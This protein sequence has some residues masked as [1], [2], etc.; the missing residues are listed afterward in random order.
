M[1]TT[2]PL[3][4]Y[5]VHHNTTTAGTRMHVAYCA[6]PAHLIPGHTRFRCLSHIPEPLGRGCSDIGTARAVLLI[7][8]VVVVVVGRFGPRNVLCY[9]WQIK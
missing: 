9:L 1:G 3:H 4:H 7:V 8:D 5:T 6:S 2:T